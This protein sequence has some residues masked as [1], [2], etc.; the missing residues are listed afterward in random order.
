MAPRTGYLKVDTT[1]L[2]A[3]LFDE[4]VMNGSEFFIHIGNWNSQLTQLE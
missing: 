3:A 2:D 4:I 1:I